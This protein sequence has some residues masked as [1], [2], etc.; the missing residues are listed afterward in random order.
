MKR[1]EFYNEKSESWLNAACDFEN[2]G[3]FN[4]DKLAEARAQE[5]NEEFADIEFRLVDC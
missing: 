3:S 4:D 5:L 2:A 1:V